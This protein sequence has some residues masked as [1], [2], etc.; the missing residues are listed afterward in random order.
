M[1][2]RLAFSRWD[3]IPAV[4]KAKPFWRGLVRSFIKLLIK[5]SDRYLAAQSTD[6]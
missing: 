5:R 6:S 1:A 4:P 2:K 3:N